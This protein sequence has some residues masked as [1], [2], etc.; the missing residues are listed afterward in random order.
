MAENHGATYMFMCLEGVNGGAVQ[1]EAK[2]IVHGNEI[3]L[4]SFETHVTGSNAA[5]T[6]GA[7][8]AD[9]P[10][11]TLG[12]VIS[13]A[14]PSLWKAACAGTVF[15]RVTISCRKHGASKANPD[16]MQWRFSDVQ[17]VDYSLKVEDDKPVETIQISYQ[18]VE[19]FYARQEQD[20]MLKDPV[21][22]SWSLDENKE[23]P[24]TL[25]Y[26]PK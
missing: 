14:S 9:F 5:T 20:G 6:E 24:I 2:D 22:R 10:P 26:V 8:K 19:V 23:A 4:L 1:G 21:K 17:V 16:Y 15:K 18:V 25:P 3:Q 12:I 13:K 11:V 7:W